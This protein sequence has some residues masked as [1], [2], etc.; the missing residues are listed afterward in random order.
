MMLY[1]LQCDI[2]STCTNTLE[3][4]SLLVAGPYF[5]F[6][7]TKFIIF[8]TKVIISKGFL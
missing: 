8:N 6:L 3:Q 4:L 5:A 2:V 1:E 7:N